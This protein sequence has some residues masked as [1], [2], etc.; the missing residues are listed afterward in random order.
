MSAD[1][2]QKRWAAA[3]LHN[4]PLAKLIGME[5]VD[6]RPGKAVIKIEMRDDF[7]QPSGVLHGGVSATLIDPAMAFA[8][9]THLKDSEP[10]ATIDPYGPLFEA[11]FI[12]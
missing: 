6:V 10:T 9:R 5:L 3:S 1:E 7:R 2:D 8:A 12:G 11:A 4:L